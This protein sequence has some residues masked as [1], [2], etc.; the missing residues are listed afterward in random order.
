MSVPVASEV[1]SNLNWMSHGKGRQGRESK[2]T[3]TLVGDTER[4]PVG[5]VGEDIVDGTRDRSFAPC[6][7]GISAKMVNLSF[8]AV[9]PV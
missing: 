8:A 9:E 2:R 3:V 7:E 1:N 5:A 6:A 4:L